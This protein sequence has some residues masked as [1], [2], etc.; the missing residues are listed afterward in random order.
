M[1][2]ILVMVGAI[3]FLSGC[4]TTTTK[5]VKVDDA[6]LA[7]EE[8]KQKEFAFNI[9]LE[10]YERISRVAYPILKN[11]VDICDEK[12]GPG[13]G[14]SMINSYSLGKGFKDTANHLGYGN[15]LKI[16]HVL[17]DSPGERAGLMRGDSLIRFGEIVSETGEKALPKFAEKF[18]ELIKPNVEYKLDVLRGNEK[19][20]L[21]LLTDL[22]CDFNLVVS[23][24][25][26]I[27]AFADGK[28]IIFTTG[29]MRF[30]SKDSELALVIGHELAHNAMRHIEKKQNNA[31][32]GLV[33]DILIA[34]AGVDTGGAFSKAAGQAYSQD[35]EA[36]ADYVGMYALSKSGMDIET[37]TKT[38]LFWRRMG[39][40]HSGAIKSQLAASHP[41]TPERF[42]ALDKT[43]EEIKLK[44]STGQPLTPDLKEDVVQKANSDEEEFP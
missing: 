17:K 10:N 26:Q 15:E 8:R 27:N 21:T 5:R 23:E 13:V 24:N 30:A 19:L 44:V 11:A 31:A 7:V 3:I 12:V 29:M 16:T 22:S 37:I 39:G 43:I 20:Q 28:N 33:L 34:L 4:Q 36:E 14:F 25:D 1:R 6:L 42:L 38:P 32:G 2:C 18:K 41:A 35:F 9:R 40:N